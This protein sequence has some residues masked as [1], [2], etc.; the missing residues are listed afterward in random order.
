MNNLFEQNISVFNSPLEFSLRC[1]CIINKEENQGID[2]DRLVYY[3]YLILNTGDI[4]DLPSLHPAL[5][6]RGAQVLVKREIIKHALVLLISKQLI[7]LKLDKK[8]IRYFKNKLTSPFISFLESNYL[9]E[10]DRR[11]TWVSENFNNYSDD[12]LNDFINKNMDK[13]GGEF[14][15]ES[16]FRNTGIL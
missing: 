8:G 2:L 5:P 1:L 15:K 4:A 14:V 13:W 16:I 7:D 9:K 10:L 6:F 12:K 11:I 3:D